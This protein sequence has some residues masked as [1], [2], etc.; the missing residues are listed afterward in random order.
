MDEAADRGWKPWWSRG[1]CVPLHKYADICTV[2]HAWLR[3]RAWSI[4]DT[5][6]YRQARM[7]PGDAS[8]PRS[9]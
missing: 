3:H 1:F 2:L 4:Q 8:V 6:M 7:A 9:R 5:R